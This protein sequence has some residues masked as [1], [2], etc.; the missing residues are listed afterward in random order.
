MRRRRDSRQQQSRRMASGT[1]KI[2][3]VAAHCKLCD[4]KSDIKWLCVICKDL[5]CEQCKL[6]HTKS[7]L[8]CNHTIVALEEVGKHVEQSERIERRAMCEL[9]PK[10]IFQMFCKDCQVLVCFDCISGPHKNHTF[11]KIS[12][13]LDSKRKELAKHVEESKQKIYCF[14][15]SMKSVHKNQKEYSDQIN[16]LIGDIKENNKRLKGEIDRITD[17]IIQQLQKKQKKDQHELKKIEE[18]ISEN[19]SNLKEYVKKSDKKLRAR[20]D[21]G[22]FKFVSKMKQKLEQYEQF[23][24]PDKLHPPS[25]IAGI[26]DWKMLKVLIGYFEDEN[27]INYEPVQSPPSIDVQ[28]VS[29]FTPR[30]DL[31]AAVNNNRAWITLGH[32]VRQTDVLEL[33]TANGH[34]LR[35]LKVDLQPRISD[36][37]VTPAGDLLVSVYCEEFIRRLTNDSD[38]FVNL[39]TDPLLCKI[40]GLSV[41]S[42]G[43]ILVTA[44]D[45]LNCKIVKLSASGKILQNIQ[46]NKDG[47]PMLISPKHVRQNSNNGDICVLKDDNEVVVVNKT[48]DVKFSYTGPLNQKTVNKVHFTNVETDRHGNILVCDKGNSTIHLV[49]KEG[50]FIQYLM[51]NKDGLVGPTGMSIDSDGKVWVSNEHAKILVAKYIP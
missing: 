32:D 6:K 11:I 47:P 24:K 12:E 48:G 46:F 36:M 31:V 17:E 2:A 30:I 3:Q 43:E 51:S 9:H 44:Y 42:I 22:M 14:T 26:T 39:K 34:V 38:K 49:D 45:G 16:K 23:T 25:F 10:Q 7:K 20:N 33:V 27:E 40:I 13:V 5:M 15:E 4:K 28:I 37:A 1:T 18:K 8:Y 29:T 50:N 35:C 21:I 19:L 41:T